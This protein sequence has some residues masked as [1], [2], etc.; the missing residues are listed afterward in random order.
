MTNRD[1]SSGHHNGGLSDAITDSTSRSFS[2][3]LTYLES[4]HTKNIDMGLDRINTVFQRLNISLKNSTVVTVAG[5]NGKGSTCAMVEYGLMQAGKTVAVYSSPHL[6]DY[7]ERVRINGQMLEPQSHCDAFAR[8]E[9]ARGDISLTFF[10]FATL[11]AFVLIAESKVDIALLEV[12]LGGRLDAVNIIDPDLAVITGIDIDHKEWLGDDREVIGREKAGIMRKGINVVVGDPNPPASIY[13]VASEVQCR[14]LWQGDEFGYEE[15]PSAWHWRHGDKILSHLPLPNIPVQ[16]ASTALAVLMQLGIELTPSQLNNVL[17][18]MTLAGRCQIVHDAPRVML[19]V[20]HN[21]Q[22]TGY[23]ARQIR[24]FDYRALHFVVG[25]LSDKDI[26][27][28][29]APLREFEAS[30]NLVPLSVPR[31]ASTDMLKPLLVGH[32][33]VIDFTSVEEALDTVTEKAHSDD[34]VIVFGSFFTVADALKKY[35]R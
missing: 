27:G 4:I 32:Q 31:G 23:L 29:L 18:G 10:E 13:D 19:D 25:M 34:L 5:T 7:R 11:A 22:A 6:L 30:W 12:G 28:S 24:R 35:N 14:C 9:E 33:T 8:V 2:E 17:Q 1:V 3:W 26:E 20:A 21:P 15:L 16:N